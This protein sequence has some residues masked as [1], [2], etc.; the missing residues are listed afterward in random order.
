MELFRRF[1]I[2]KIDGSCI[3]M[4]AVSGSATSVGGAETALNA[5]V[6]EVAESTPSTNF[7]GSLGAC[8]RFDI[9]VRRV[10]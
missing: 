9:I 1:Y 6:F 4:E 7:W 10:G 8:H 5:L 3:R 2:E